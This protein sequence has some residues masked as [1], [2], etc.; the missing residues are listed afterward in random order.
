MLTYLNYV[1]LACALGG[2]TIVLAQ[3]FLAAFALGSGH[4]MHVHHHGSPAVHHAGGN[5]SHS[6]R[7]M[8]HRGGSGPGT[9]TPAAHGARAISM[10]GGA[11]AIHA[12][13]PAHHFSLRDSWAFSHLL[14]IF[15]FQGMVAGA[16]VLGFA[17]LAATSAR[18]PELF[19]LLIAITA[20]FVMMISVSAVLRAMTSMD[21]DGTVQ[22]EGAVGALGTVYLS[23]PAGGNERGKITLKLQQRLMEFPAVTQAAPLATGDQVI[24]VAVRKPDVMEVV[25]AEKYLRD[26][27]ALTDGSAV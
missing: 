14:G 11:A 13:A 3:L 10:K 5:A 6:L 7:G 12:G 26:T 22:I 4:G 16:T 24:V 9:G 18:L 1:F 15:N 23:I 19:V 17:G 21:H 8:L 27:Q 20:A 2:G 25:S